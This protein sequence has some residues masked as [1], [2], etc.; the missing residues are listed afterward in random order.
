MMDRIVMEVSRYRPEIES[1]P[2]FQAYEVPLT[3]EWAVLDGLTYI[4]DHLDGTL[5]FRWSCRMGICGSSGMT[6]NGDPK[7]ACAT[8]LADYLP[9]PVRVEPMRNFPVIRDLVV[10]ISDFMAKLP[11]VK[12][13]L[14]RHDEPPVE[15]GEYRQTPAELD[16]FKQFSM[17]IN[18]MLCYSACPVYALDPDFLGPAAIA[19]GQRY[20]L[21]SRD[22][23]AADRRDVLAAADGAWA[24]TLVGE[25]AFLPAIHASR[26]QL[27][28]RGLVCSLSGAGIARRWRGRE[29][30]P[31]V[32]GLQRQ[33]GCRSAE[34]RRVEFPAAACC[35]LVR[36]GT[37][38][39]GDSGSRPPGTRSRGPCWALRGMAG[40]FGDRCLD[41]AVMTPSTSD[42]RSRR[43]SAEP[44]LWLLFSAGGMVTALV[45]PVLLLLFG[46]AF[47]LGWL[48]APD[49]GHLLAMV[50]N[51]ITKLVVLVLVVLALFHAAHRFRFVL[52]H[53]LQLG[54]F[55]RVI[56]LWC[57][58][59]AVLGSATAGWMLL[60][61]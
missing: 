58:G 4:K 41:G 9:G 30:L 24:C 32:F 39:D 10:D 37:A 23:G 56:A 53:G 57:Y 16:A 54:R 5:S 17:C 42:A 25:A 36:I 27:H 59:M 34:R 46:L 31:A 2:T 20:N 43:R 12:P 45:A 50:R 35:Y 13:W 60:T 49:H 48:D 7:L 29:F 28:L 8:F 47:P 1:A 26:N 3:R 51:P 21:D 11:S 15:D 55:D 19:L 40:G 33:S 44:F 22:Q 52:D 18:C 38:R 14:V 61:M 6:I